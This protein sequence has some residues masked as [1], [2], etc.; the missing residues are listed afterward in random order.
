MDGPTRSS[1][2]YAATTAATLDFCAD[3]Y[4]YDLSFD[5][6]IKIVEASPEVI[7]INRDNF[8]TDYQLDEAVVCDCKYKRPSR[9]VV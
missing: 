2:S 3:D 5:S 8:E 7:P 9:R 6:N 4:L 1:D